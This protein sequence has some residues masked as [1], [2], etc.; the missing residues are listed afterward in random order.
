MRGFIQIKVFKLG[1]PCL[2]G[3]LRISFCRKFLLSFFVQ[4]SEKGGYSK[5]EEMASTCED[6]G[7][8]SIL[9]GTFGF[10]VSVNKSRARSL[11]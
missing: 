2:R 5:V 9:F 1:F 8:H 7:I 6:K 11:R 3:K 4:V 10:R